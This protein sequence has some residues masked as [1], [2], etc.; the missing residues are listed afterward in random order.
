L[1]AFRCRGKRPIGRALLV[2]TAAA[3]N[4]RYI[5]AGVG[6][7]A[8]IEDESDDSGDLGLHGG[9]R[10]RFITMSSAILL[11]FI[12]LVL[13]LKGLWWVRWER[14]ETEVAFLRFLT[15]PLLCL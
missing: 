9:G 2:G 4:S 5:K 1:G 7:I 12:F 6:I 11:C 13:Y 14:W 10:A 15:H 8:N 3:C